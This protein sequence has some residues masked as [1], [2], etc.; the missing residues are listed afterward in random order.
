[1]NKILKW[2]IV[3]ISMISLVTLFA[4]KVYAENEEKVNFLS[5]ESNNATPGSKVN[6]ILN[7]NNITYNSYTIALSSDT[8]IS[9]PTVTS[10]NT[11]TEVGNVQEGG[12][13]NNNESSNTTNSEVENSTANNQITNNVENTNTNTKEF[14][15]SNV[16]NLDN[17]SIAVTIPED[18]QIGSQITFTIKVTDSSNSENTLSSQVTINVVASTENNQQE[19]NINNENQMNNNFN[20]NQQSSGS[21]MQQM[22]G[23]GSSSTTMGNS[24]LTTQSAS[25][26]SL[27]GMQS[28]TQTVTYDGSSDNYLTDIKIDGESVSNFNKTNSTYFKTLDEG[29]AST[30]I[31]YTQSDSSSTVCIYGNTNLKSGLNK[32]LLT[33]TAENG[34]VRYYRIY[35]TV[36]S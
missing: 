25:T 23:T 10:P 20:G 22:Q 35:I 18:A 14:T 5:V 32:I 33:V 24:S 29:T 15:I 19:E 27:S 8:D 7:L 3:L 12:A 26:S 34:S 4:I 21:T 6:L 28:T 11:G 13:S 2:S 31:S 1:M 30:E 16:S 17:I 9:K 36:K